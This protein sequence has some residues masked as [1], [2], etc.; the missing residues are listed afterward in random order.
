MQYDVIT[1]AHFERLYWI[2]RRRT[3]ALSI[4]CPCAPTPPTAQLVSNSRFSF[5]FV[6]FTLAAPHFFGQYDSPSNLAESRY[7]PLDFSKTFVC[8]VSSKNGPDDGIPR[9][10]GLGQITW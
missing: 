3:F 1:K 6:I 5:L 4:N 7:P 8:L 2:P 10:L 9:V